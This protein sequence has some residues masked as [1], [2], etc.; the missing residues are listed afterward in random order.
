[1]NHGSSRHPGQFV[2]GIQNCQIWPG[3]QERACVRARMAGKRVSRWKPS[4]YIPM[5]YGV[6]RFALRIFFFFFHG[7]HWI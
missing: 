6:Y 2:R 1:M 5:V 3:P 4:V 7:E